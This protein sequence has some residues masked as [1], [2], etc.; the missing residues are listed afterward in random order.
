MSKVNH[1][2]LRRYDQFGFSGATCFPPGPLHHDK[3]EPFTRAK[4]LEDKLTKL[5]LDTGE[6]AKNILRIKTKG[7]KFELVSSQHREKMLLKRVDEIG[8]FEKC[9]GKEGDGQLQEQNR[10]DGRVSLHG[11]C[12]GTPLPLCPQYHIL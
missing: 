1:E 11:S 12:E 10:R 5:A 3:L 7:K 4:D 6:D 9:R 8:Y 2:H